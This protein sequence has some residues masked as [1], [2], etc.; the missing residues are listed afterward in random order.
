[1]TA[2]LL[3]AAR[4]EALFVS[5]LSAESHPTRAEVTAAIR[6]AV[7]THG[8]TRG[9][10]IEVAGAYGDYPETAAPRMFWALGVVHAAYSQVRPRR[11][12]RRCEWPV[13]RPNRRSRP[14][15]GTSISST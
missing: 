11:S 4:A 9:C 8:G 3:T 5:E 6:R 10:S 13:R 12:S 7:R 14:D 15:A 2:D 1:M